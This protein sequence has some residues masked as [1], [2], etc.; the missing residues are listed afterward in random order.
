MSNS[1]LKPEKFK[2]G[3]K[4]SN[5]I[6]DAFPELDENAQN[7]PSIEQMQGKM[8]LSGRLNSR[9]TNIS[10]KFY[11]EAPEDTAE[12]LFEEDKENEEMDYYS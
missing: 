11:S 7:L 6:R 2:Y 1:I 10:D 9:H 3:T 12:M 4:V 8:F 5:Q